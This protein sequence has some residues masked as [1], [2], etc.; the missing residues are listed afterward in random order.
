MTGATDTAEVAVG[1]LS[2]CPMVVASSVRRRTSVQWPSN[3]AKYSHC[4]KATVR[5]IYGTNFGLS[6]PFSEHCTEKTLLLVGLSNGP[7]Q[8]QGQSCTDERRL[9]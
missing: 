5:S 2:F 7:L 9:L 6:L 3:R 1:L 4:K 8:R